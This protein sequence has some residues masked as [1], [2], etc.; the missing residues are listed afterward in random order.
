MYCHFFV[1]FVYVQRDFVWIYYSHVIDVVCTADVFD[2]HAG[3]VI[4]FL[5]RM[6]FPVVFVYPNISIH[7]L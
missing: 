4:L 2:C 6:L 3:K 5:I 1:A 7:L